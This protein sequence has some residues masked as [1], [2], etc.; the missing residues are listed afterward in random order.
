MISVRITHAPVDLP[1][2]QQ[3]A[4]LLSG[5]GVTV[6]P[7]GTRPAAN[8]PAALLVVLYS[9]A[10]AATDLAEVQRD[11]ARAITES[12]L[13][14]VVRT[15]SV[16]LPASLATL[17]GNPAPI[18]WRPSDP[19]TSQQVC[20][21]I[22]ALATAA[23]PASMTS[24]AATPKPLDTPDVPGRDFMRPSPLPS[25]SQSLTP[26]S[27]SPQIAAPSRDM[28]SRLAATV[29][30]NDGEAEVSYVGGGS[31]PPRIGTAVSEMNDGLNDLR[32]TASIDAAPRPGLAGKIDR[33]EV[34][35]VLG[36]GGMGVVLL[37]RD[38]NANGA[39]VA[40]KT[41]AARFVGNARAQSRFVKEANNMKRMTHP[42]VLKVTECVNRPNGAYYVMPFI[43]AGSM[44]RLLDNDEPADTTLLLNVAVQIADA[45]R[46][47]HDDA[48]VLHRDIKPENVLV[49][50][51]G[52]AYLSD[53]G[54][55]RSLVV[56]ETVQEGERGW[57]VGTARYMAPEIADGKAGDTR[58]D[59]YSFGAM[60]YELATGVAPYEDTAPSATNERILDRI[61]HASPT[62]VLSLN[63]SILPD[64]ARLIEGAMARELR[65]R[66]AHMKD[67]LEDLKRIRRGLPIRGAKD[68]DAGSAVGSGGA[69]I[70]PIPA[71]GTRAA[72]ATAPGIS[73]PG[74]TATMTPPTVTATPAA[75]GSSNRAVKLVG[76]VLVVLILL[77]GLLAGGAWMYGSRLLAMVQ[78]ATTHPTTQRTDNP[79]LA[80]DAQKAD[81]VAIA[82]TTRQGTAKA[83]T[84]SGTGTG[85]AAVATKANAPADM[86]A[87]A[88]TATHSTATGS[89]ASG[90]AAAANT[91]ANTP[92]NTAASV[93][94]AASAVSSWLTGSGSSSTAGTK[95]ATPDPK[96]AN[97]QGANTSSNGSSNRSAAAANTSV[98]TPSANKATV[99]DTTTNANPAGGPNKPPSYFAL[100]SAGKTLF[101]PQPA[102][103]E[104]DEDHAKRAVHEI[105]DNVTRGQEDIALEQLDAMTTLKQ[106]EM[107]SLSGEPLLNIAAEH[108]RVRVLRYLVTKRKFDINRIDGFVARTPLDCAD[109]EAT[110][111]VI[112]DELGGK[113]KAELDRR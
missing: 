66:Y 111:K 100:D 51:S 41:I 102:E 52:H 91:A 96:A 33:F 44:A 87:S 69:A 22:S 11:V 29:D 68:A 14:A 78:G 89:T 48:G 101:D 59:I 64:L 80:A 83:V 3:L 58:A 67:V 49:D 99:P 35:R 60:L 106:F 105:A 4:A 39:T 75:A 55:V 92:A 34:I 40:I 82:D 37:A 45:L 84:D 88:D 112:R 71:S 1:L 70:P 77:G 97:A 74:T 107:N 21:A 26:A 110:R 54:L 93:S 24:V 62:A 28:Q 38:P 73:M 81:A 10:V 30:S 13:V 56:N 27:G 86:K 50:S 12:G 90:T 2:S 15:S 47:A 79:P 104:S 57:T 95:T 42:N 72:A 108:G 53:F 18:D 17:I 25:Q 65:D 61:L 63:P 20:Q 113:T 43:D 76:A 23:S 94:G 46:Y 7:V 98:G 5:E 9:D 16:P 31:G 85:T 36:Q 103:G 109:D 6:M 32:N 19:A 8:E